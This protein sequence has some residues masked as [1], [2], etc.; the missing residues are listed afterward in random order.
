MKHFLFVSV[1]RYLKNIYQLKEMEG[2]KKLSAETNMEKVSTNDL[3]F[4][5]ISYHLDF[6]V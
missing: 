5:V 3:N 1:I 6:S 2:E 4:Q